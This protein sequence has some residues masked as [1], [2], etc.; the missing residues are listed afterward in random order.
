[1]ADD[2]VCAA[3]RWLGPELNAVIA[4]FDRDWL[5][6]NGEAWREH[7][8]YAVEGEGKLAGFAA[9]F[10]ELS[11]EDTWA[12]GNL[13]LDLRG[14]DE[15]KPVFEE[16]SRRHPENPQAAWILGQLLMHENDERFLA[17]MR[18]A[19]GHADPEVTLSATSWTAEWLDSQDRRDEAKEW[20]ADFERLITG[21][22]AAEAEREE[23]KPKDALEETALDEAIE[24]Q[25][26]EVLVNTGVVKHAWVAQKVVEHQPH[27]PAR[28][29]AFTM[30]G[31]HLSEEGPVRKV[32]KA[33]IN[34][35]S[36]TPLFTFVVAASGETKKLAKRIKKTGRQI[37]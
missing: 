12:Y 15:A 11:D 17:H 35:E 13:L 4:D 14:N 23:L 37:L 28:A 3:E 8:Q 29:L 20:R 36:P 27:R 16:F 22:Q 18:V 24:A 19:R 10:P 7:H 21:Y 32:I 33:V 5:D 2:T 25:L 26:R 9:Q 6:H 30:K 34:E 1:P 31:M